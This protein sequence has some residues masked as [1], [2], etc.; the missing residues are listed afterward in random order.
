[1]PLRDRYSFRSLLE[2]KYVKIF[3]HLH[4]PYS[5]IEKN[6]A[7]GTLCIQ[8]K[9]FLTCTPWKLCALLQEDNAAKEFR[10]QSEVCCNVL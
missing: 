2:E 8:Q 3:L 1:M 4:G 9:L 5:M 7:M 10:Q 6:N